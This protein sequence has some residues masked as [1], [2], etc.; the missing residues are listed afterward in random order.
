MIC[1][2]IQKSK[3]RVAIIITQPELNNMIKTPR[4][5]G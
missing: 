3:N 1:C 4:K 2:N 5:L